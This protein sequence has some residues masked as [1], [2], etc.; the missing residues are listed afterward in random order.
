MPIAIG[1]AETARL[2]TAMTAF[3]DL[4]ESAD[5]PIVPFIP[6]HLDGKPDWTRDFERHY[7]YG[8]GRR[9]GS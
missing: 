9:T 4:V 5:P 2:L 1:R 7:K 6:K 8:I 3:T